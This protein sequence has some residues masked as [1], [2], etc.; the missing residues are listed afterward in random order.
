MRRL[1]DIDAGV[2]DQ[3]V[4]P[5]TMIHRFV[6]ERVNRLLVGNIYLN[7]ERVGANRPQLADRGIGFHLVSGGHDDARSGLR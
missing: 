6:H 7:G 2:V 5:P 1:P 3:D 4:K